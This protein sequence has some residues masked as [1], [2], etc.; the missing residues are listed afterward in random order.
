VH[1]YSNIVFIFFEKYVTRYN[2]VVL[3]D[4]FIEMTESDRAMLWRFRY[5]LRKSPS[6]IPKFLLAVNWFEPESVAEAYNLL[7]TWEPFSFVESLQMLDGRF[8]DPKVRAAA[9]QMLGG[10][11]DTELLSF[12]LQLTQ[13]LKFEQHH[14]SALARFLLRR[15]IASPEKIGQTFFWFLRSEV[16]LKEIQKRN[17]ILTTIFLKS[18]GSYQTDLGHQMLVLQRLEDVAAIVKSIP[19]KDERLR[20]L[21][22]RLSSITFPSSF[23]LPLHST[24]RVSR[25]ILSKCR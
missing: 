13:L 19:S 18:V 7:Y 14:D 9:V 22:E 10:L 12:L 16:H 15:A 17:E 20:T 4:P 21:K 8:P 2:F 24:I 11:T 3:S 1:G 5:I 6:L 23:Q 25:L